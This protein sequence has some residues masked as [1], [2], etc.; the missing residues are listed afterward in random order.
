MTPSSNSPL[1]Q[2]HRGPSIVVLERGDFAIVKR[3]TGSLARP[4]GTL[5]LFLPFE[6]IVSVAAVIEG[7]QAALRFE[8]AFKRVDRPPQVV[9]GDFDAAEATD[10]AHLLCQRYGLPRIPRVLD[11][12]ALE[13]LREPMYVRVTGHCFRSHIETANFGP[14][15]AGRPFLFVRGADRSSLIPERDYQVTGFFTPAPEVTHFATGGNGPRIEALQVES[16]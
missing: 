9:C 15:A 12:Q 8:G 3:A 2:I 11:V 10:V 16:V 7:G 13:Q 1:I 6:R 14:N 4:R 5:E